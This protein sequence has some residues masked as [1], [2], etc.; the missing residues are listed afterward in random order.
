[1][2]YPHLTTPRNLLKQADVANYAERTLRPLALRRA[3]I[4]RPFLVAIL[5]RKPWVRLRFITLG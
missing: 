3:R 1:M 4:L 2:F 5:A